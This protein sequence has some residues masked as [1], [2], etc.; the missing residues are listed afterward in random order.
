M[1]VIGLNTQG[2]TGN[3]TASRSTLSSQHAPQPVPV[4]RRAGV[5]F[6]SRGDIA[7]PHDSLIAD[8]RVVVAQQTYQRSKPAVLDSLVGFVVLSFQFD[9]D[10]EIITAFACLVARLPRVPGAMRERDVLHQFAIAANQHV[11]GNTQVGNFREI[12][13]YRR[14]QQPPYSP[15][16]KLIPCTT[17]SEMSQPAG[18]S[19]QFGD[20]TRRT[21]PNQAPSAVSL[22][23]VHL[24]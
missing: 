13:M 3:A 18:R 17:T 20:I 5:G 12:G 8:L 1:S 4:E 23:S 21:P 19:S 15:G 2:S 9:T 11:R 22:I 14:I 16:G 6:A 24:S 7:V 10:R